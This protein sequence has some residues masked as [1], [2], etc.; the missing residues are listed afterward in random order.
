MS[1]TDHFH[2]IVERLIRESPKL[3]FYSEDV[4]QREGKYA[5]KYG[6]R[7]S[8][9]PTTLAVHPDILRLFPKYAGSNSLTLETGCGYTTIALAALSKHHICISPDKMGRHLVEQYMDAIGIPRHKVTFIEQTS[10][11][12]LPTLSLDEQLDFAYVDGCHGYPFPALDWHFIDQHLKVNGYI[13]FDNVEIPTVKLHCDFMEANRAYSLVNR[14]IF[15]GRGGYQ[16]NIYQKQKAEQR[17][18]VFQQFNERKLPYPTARVPG[19]IERALAKVL[20][21]R[22]VQVPLQKRFGWPK[23]D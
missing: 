14:I 16:V 18:W 23:R 10:E 20:P 15:D 3:H 4:V 17:E 7:L 5:D 9:G 12:A 22:L 2:G 8:A 19:R 6:Y 11:T 1:I 13:G 21:W